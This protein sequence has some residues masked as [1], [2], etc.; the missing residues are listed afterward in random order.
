M[1][2]LPK[3]TFSPLEVKNKHIWIL[4]FKM[5][6]RFLL[7]GTSMN[8]GFLSQELYSKYVNFNHNKTNSSIKILSLIVPAPQGRQ[9]PKL[10]EIKL[11]D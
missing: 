9:P 6:K 10:L 5:W 1:Y 11:G 8:T 2:I 7:P 4:S 3:F